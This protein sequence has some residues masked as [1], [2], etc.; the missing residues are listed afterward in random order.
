MKKVLLSITA[1]ALVAG[2]M[3]FTSCKKGEN[4]PAISFKS[5]KGRLAGEWTVS[6]YEATGSDTWTSSGLS[7]TDKYTESFDGTTWTSVETDSDGDITET[8]ANVSEWTFTFEKDGTYSTKQGIT[9]TEWSYTPSGGS[10][11]T[12]AVTT[13]NVYSMEEAGNW[14]FVGKDKDGEYKNKERVV[15]NTGSST[16]I[17]PSSNCQGTDKTVTTYSNGENSSIWDIDQ[18][19][20]KEI[21]VKWSKNMVS[22]DTPNGGTTS[23]STS[24]EDGMMTLTAK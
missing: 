16:D 4:D 3:T 21:I 8:K 6:S 9:I 17:S 23:S 7:A 14:S 18:L 1:F 12:T 11:V 20:S 15:L 10:K 13:C 24:V 22:T 2:S 19:K 5:R